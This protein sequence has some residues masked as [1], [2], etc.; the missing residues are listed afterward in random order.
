MQKKWTHTAAFAHFGMKPRNVQWSW[1]ARNE[2]TKTVV[3][4]LWQDEFV[5]KN[6]RLTYSRPG[7]DPAEPDTRP[8]L[9]ELMDNFV[10]A[11]EHSDGRFRVII[12]RAKDKNAEPRSIVECF[13]S[14][15]TMRLMH[16]NPANGAWAAVAEGI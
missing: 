9:R 15:M 13:P 5:K 11:Q 10:W 2:A 1:S 4:T 16:L 7:F 6:G 12:A 14:K 8:G 3:V